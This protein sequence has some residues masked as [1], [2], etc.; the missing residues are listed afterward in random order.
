VNHLGCEEVSERLST[1]YEIASRGGYHC[2]ALAHKTIGTY[3]TGA[4]RLSVGPYNTK[5]EI[6]MAIEAVYQIQKV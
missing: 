3:E 4:V 2:A 5:W 6:K 1:D